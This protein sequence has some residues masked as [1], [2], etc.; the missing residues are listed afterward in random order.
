VR[1]VHVFGVASIMVQPSFARLLMTSLWILQDKLGAKMAISNTSFED[2]AARPR[3]I[4]DGR[5]IGPVWRL[6]HAHSLPS[7]KNQLFWQNRGVRVL[8]IVNLPLL[9][10]TKTGRKK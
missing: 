5:S 1:R 4:G 3:Q 2:M 6:L 9:T 7:G 8:A 10:A